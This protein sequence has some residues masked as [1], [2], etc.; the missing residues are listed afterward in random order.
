MTNAHRAR[1]AGGRGASLV[2]TLEDFAGVP[3]QVRGAY[4]AVGNFDGVHRGHSHLVARLR[5]NAEAAGAP[6]VALT[7]DPHPVQLLRPE[8][9]PVPL[10][11]TERKAALLEE[12][13]AT[14]VGVFRTGPWLLGLT[15]REFFDR[16]IV[17]RL[18]A[19]GMVEGP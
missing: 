11:W 1:T 16:I 2:I 18:Q 19:R 7:F 17:G 6:A 8:E 14:E 12:A 5:A 9:A 4:V 13:G 3:A 10:V 15:A